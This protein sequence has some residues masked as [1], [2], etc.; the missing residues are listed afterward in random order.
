MG[1]NEA[2]IVFNRQRN[3]TAL[4]ARRLRR[5]YEESL[6][7]RAASHPKRIYAHVRS[8]SR[9]KNQI[10]ALKNA[11]VDVVTEPAH[12]CQIL[13][14]T[15]GAS[16]RRDEGKDPP[17]FFRDAVPLGARSIFPENVLPILIK[18]DPHKGHGPGDIHLRLFKLLANF[19][20][21]PLAHLFNLTLSE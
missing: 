12:K 15:F 16:F 14:D 7:E 2:L 1:T 10:P 8:K 21:A 17:P 11:A 20:A 19:V 13:A 4:L 3:R 9:L 6:A 5:A 18:L